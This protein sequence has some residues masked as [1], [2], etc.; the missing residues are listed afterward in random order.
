MQAVSAPI[1]GL[2]PAH[3]KPEPLSDINQVAEHVGMSVQNVRRL[4]LLE[5]FPRPIRVGNSLR[6][7]LSA[8]DGYFCGGSCDE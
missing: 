5:R 6:W 2:V 4:I 7:K 8:V 3:F 1:S